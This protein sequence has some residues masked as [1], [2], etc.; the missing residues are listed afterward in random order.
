MLFLS[1]PYILPNILKM[2]N[3]MAAINKSVCCGA[4][5]VRKSFLAINYPLLCSNVQWSES[6]RVFR[7]GAD[8]YSPP[9]PFNAV[10]HIYR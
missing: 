4:G 2:V 3:E 9:H 1:V 5:V 6:K 8:C 10:C 7:L